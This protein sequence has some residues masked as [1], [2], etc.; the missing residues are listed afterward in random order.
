M[1]LVAN[2]CIEKNINGEN[3]KESIRVSVCSK[4]TIVYITILNKVYIE[5]K[6]KRQ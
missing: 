3:I 6:I 4:N 2:V 5:M 1:R